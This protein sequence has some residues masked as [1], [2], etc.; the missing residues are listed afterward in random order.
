MQ[1]D[2]FNERLERRLKVLDASVPPA[3]DRY[4]REAG[5]VGTGGRNRV[6]VRGRLPIG[7]AAAVAVLAVAVASL[8]LIRPSS[9]PGGA[10]G[11]TGSETPASPAVA[12]SPGESA[13]PEPG[14]IVTGGAAVLA[15]ATDDRLMV[16]LSITNATGRDDRLVRASSTRATAG[17][18]AFSACSAVPSGL[19]GP[20][21]SPL[22]IPW[23]AL[24]AGET[25]EF[26]GIVLSG[27]R[28]ASV[29]GDTVPVTLLFAFASPV[30][31]QIPVLAQWPTVAAP[32]K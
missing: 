18:Y 12:T 31:L 19:G 23:M 7:I 17:L 15:S 13:S 21:S 24:L 10:N 8:G 25:V 26:D 11:A 3:S 30:T 1:R 14:M 9:N 2:I 16:H 22:V 28:T 4:D 20:C 6:R 27:F 29:P 5:H 32:S